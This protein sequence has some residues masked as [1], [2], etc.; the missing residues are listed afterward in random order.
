MYYPHWD[1]ESE[2]EGQYNF[3][4]F[5]LGD[6]IPCSCRQNRCSRGYFPPNVSDFICFGGFLVTGCLE[7]KPE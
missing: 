4:N 7:V 3:T 5:W 2:W 1:M 6:E